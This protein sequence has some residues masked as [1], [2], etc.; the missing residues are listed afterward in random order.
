VGIEH[1]RDVI[2]AADWG[3]ERGPEGGAAGGRVIAT[4]PPEVVAHAKHSATGNF[5]AGVLDRTNRSSRAAAG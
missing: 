4:G 1:N 3:I 2:K 5:L